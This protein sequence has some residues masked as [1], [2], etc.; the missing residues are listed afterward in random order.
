MLRH[1]MTEGNKASRYIGVTDE[2]LCEEGKEQLQKF[3]YEPGNVLFVSP[4]KRC[5][6]TAEILFPGQEQI[7]VAELAE[8]N[9]GEFENK[10]YLELSDHPKYQEW[11]DSNGEL[12]FPGGESR[13]ECMQRNWKG[14]EKVLEICR[15]HQVQKAVL[16]V[17]GGTIMNL[18]QQYAQEKRSFY[19]WHVKNGEGYDLKVSG[20]HAKSEIIFED[21]KKI[22]K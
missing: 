3:S 4:L 9:F 12:P 18:M 8:C 11:I 15:E 14:F 7:L 10:N 13:E 19:E 5:R 16:V 22:S 6:E 17:H 21:I 2:P 1:G 20:V